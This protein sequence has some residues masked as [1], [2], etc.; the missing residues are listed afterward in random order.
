MPSRTAS[1]NPSLATVR[2]Y[3]PG[4]TSGKL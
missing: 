1:A 3:L 4:C 2:R